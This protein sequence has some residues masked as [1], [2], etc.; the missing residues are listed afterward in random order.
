MES[1]TLGIAPRL[2]QDLFKSL[3]SK[4]YKIHVS[5]VELYNEQV[6]DL[7]TTSQTMSS[8]DLVIRE[9]KDGHI[10]I[11]GTTVHPC[12]TVDDV[13]YLLEKG[14]LSRTVGGTQMNHASSRSHA[15]FTLTLVQ[16]VPIKEGIGFQKLVSKLNLVDL[17][18]INSKFTF[19][20]GPMLLIDL[21]L[22]KSNTLDLHSDMFSILRILNLSHNELTSFPSELVTLHTLETLDL[23]HNSISTVSLLPISLKH[24]HLQHNPLNQLRIQNHPNLIQLNL[25]FTQL[26]TFTCEHLPE[27]ESLDLSHNQLREFIWSSLNSLKHLSVHHNSK[28]VGSNIFELPSLMHLEFE[29][30]RIR[31]DLVRDTP[32][33]KE[34]EQRR[35]GRIDQ[36]LKV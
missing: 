16:T 24:L 19:Y 13:L 11:Q 20:F 2:I 8:Q 4:K 15:I 35:K 21:L 9:D 5:F 30:T 10:K 6:R 34:Y 26:V 14:A 27:L 36:L 1:D 31:I 22:T 12:K 23:S 25:Q 3:E 32:E 28:F 18:G 17:A 33:Y 7:F 29:Q